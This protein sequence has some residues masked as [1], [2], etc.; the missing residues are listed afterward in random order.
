MVILWLIIMIRMMWQ[1][2]NER[3]DKTDGINESMKP[4]NMQKL[5]TEWPIVWH[6][7]SAKTE[8]WW[9]F[10]MYIAQVYVG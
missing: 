3:D 8:S 9:T 7:A 1:K 10:N 6:W 2:D 4:I 5:I